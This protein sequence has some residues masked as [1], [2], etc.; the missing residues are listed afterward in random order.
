MY[1]WYLRE[2]SVADSGSILAEKYFIQIF[3]GT[4]TS[5]DMITV[6]LVL[7]ILGK[8]AQKFLIQ[9]PL[10]HVIC[11]QVHINVDVRTPALK[12]FQK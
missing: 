2:E 3:D 11:S 8:V 12:Q 5:E 10:H 6:V 9:V 1:P 7:C 4:K